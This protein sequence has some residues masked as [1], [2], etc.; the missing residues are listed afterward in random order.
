MPISSAGRQARLSGSVSNKRR[1]YWPNVVMPMSRAYGRP[2]SDPRGTNDDNEQQ[3]QVISRSNRGRATTTSFHQ[4]QQQKKPTE[5]TKKGSRKPE[6]YKQIRHISPPSSHASTSTAL[7]NIIKTNLERDSAS[8]DGDDLN[9]CSDDQATDIMNTIGG[10]LII[11]GAGDKQPASMPGTRATTTN[12]A[13][14]NGQSAG[15]GAHYMNRFGQQQATGK[16]L[17]MP[18]YLANQAQFQPIAN[19]AKTTSQASLHQLSMGQPSTTNSSTAHLHS[20]N[21]LHASQSTT[22]TNPLNI[23]KRVNLKY[24]KTL[25]IALM[26]IDLLITVLVYHFSSHDE[27]SLIWFTSHRLRFSLLNLILSSLW[28]IILIGAIIFDVYFILLIGCLVDIGSFI[29]LLIFSIIHFSQRIDYNTVNLTSLLA[30]LFSIIVLH[31]YLLVMAAL[32]TYLMLAVKQRK[33]SARR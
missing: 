5:T 17:R 7:H 8:I 18:D 33:R 16:L 12:V 30:L 15:A 19:N 23:S 20:L 31:V 13:T 14:T 22:G 28:F 21:N 1:A 3:S 27:I 24:I 4:P 6:R 11:T 25:I 29:L 2:T 9:K 10:Q 26:A 32:T